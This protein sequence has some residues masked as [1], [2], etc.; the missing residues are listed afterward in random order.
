MKLKSLIFV[1]LLAW[2][3]CTNQAQPFFIEKFYPLAPV[4]DI[5]AGLERIAGNG[6]LDVAANSAQFFIGIKISGA[7]N[8]TQKAV[9][10]GSIVLEREDRNRP[11]VT[12][13]VVNYRLSKRVGATPKPYIT[14][15]NLPFTEAGEIYGAF[16]LISPDLATALF[17][18]LTPS[19]TIDD[20]VDVS[21]DVEFKG[22]FSNTQAPFTT[23]VLTYPIRA[24]RSNPAACANGYVRYPEDP[25]TGT[26]DYC[27]YTGQ[28]FSQIVAPAPP[29]CCGAMGAPGC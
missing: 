7:Q 4:C 29:T 14:N 16:Q 9:T 13:Q 18:G 22:I 17:D 25:G 12:S 19:N 23:G 26:P 5:E 28:S 15:I 2:T 6:Y 24:Y 8:V 1:G 20:F 3:S 11:I 27:N 10:Q 21:V